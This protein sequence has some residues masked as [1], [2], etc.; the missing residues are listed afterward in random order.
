MNNVYEY[1]G[2]QFIKKDNYAWSLYSYFAS[3]ST[4]RKNVQRLKSPGGASLTAVKTEN[5]WGVF[6]LSPK[7][8]YRTKANVLKDLAKPWVVVLID[9]DKKILQVIY[10]NL[11]NRLESVKLANIIKK[12]LWFKKHNI[13]V[14]TEKKFKNYARRDF[15]ITKFDIEEHLKDVPKQPEWWKEYQEKTKKIEKMI[16]NKL[17]LILGQKITVESIDSITYTTYVKR[18][19]REQDKFKFGSILLPNDLDIQLEPGIIRGYSSPQ[20]YIYMLIPEARGYSEYYRARPALSSKSIEILTNPKVPKINVIEDKKWYLISTSF[21]GLTKKEA[22][23]VSRELL[24]KKVLAYK[25]YLKTIV[26]DGKYY[27]YS[28]V[29]PKTK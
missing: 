26:K 1:E 9:S 10:R 29:E 18:T 14:M 6:Q 13:R 17:N 8:E 2:T 4:A 15:K 22:E 3:E 21:Y 5:G 28:Y 24:S 16:E 19:S 7:E 12:K 23:N 25:L 27:I 20:T 11:E